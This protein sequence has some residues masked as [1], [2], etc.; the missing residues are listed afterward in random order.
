MITAQEGGKVVSLTHRPPLPPGKPLAL[1]SVRGW[2]DPKAMVRSGGL[3]QWKIPMTPSG[4]EPVTF[5]FVA[6]HLNH[7]A[8]AVSLVVDSSW[9]KLSFPLFPCTT[10][11]SPS[12]LLKCVAYLTFCQLY[13]YFL[14]DILFSPN[15]V[16]AIKSRK[17]RWAGH[18][19]R[20]GERKGVYRLL[21]G[22]S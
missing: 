21:V 22:K 10:S 6:Q 18:V 11:I 7:Y 14:F 2:V 17:M 19:A 4:V 8:T 9:L 20:I 12:A 13:M 3:C 5:R 15:I 16:R 1:I